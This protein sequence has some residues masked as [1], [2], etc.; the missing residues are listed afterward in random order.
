MRDILL[1]ILIIAV[2]VSVAS[3]LFEGGVEEKIVFSDVIR[4]FEAE[5]VEEYVIDESGMFTAKLYRADSQG[6]EIISFDLSDPQI[7]ADFRLYTSEL[8]RDQRARGII[9][10][11]DLLPE[12]GTPWWMALL[13]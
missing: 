2:L 3:F 7:R 4:Q 12:A 10:R 5:N 1:F 6:R 9:K 13:L 11:D 8:I